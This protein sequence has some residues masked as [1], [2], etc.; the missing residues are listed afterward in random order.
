M[1]RLW[2]YKFF[3][4]DGDTWRLELGQNQIGEVGG[5]FFNQLPSAAFAKF[6]QLLSHGKII[7]RITDGVAFRGL[8]KIAIHLHREQQTLRLRAFLVR[9]ANAGKTLPGQLWRF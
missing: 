2:N 5:Q 1:P 6:Q 8:G 3:D 9:H 4:F 7:N